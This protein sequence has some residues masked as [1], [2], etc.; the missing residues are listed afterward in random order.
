MLGNDRYSMS[1]ESLPILTVGSAG[2]HN[3]IFS[4][5]GPRPCTPLNENTFR[6]R[7]LETENIKD[8]VRLL[9]E[10]NEKIIKSNKYQTPLFVA[11]HLEAGGEAIRRQKLLPNIDLP[12]TRETQ[13]IELPVEDE[14]LTGGGTVY[15]AGLSATLDLSYITT[16]LESLDTCELHKPK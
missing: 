5:I 13:T 9:S 1:D 16:A 6:V 7:I 3:A 15:V 4:S 12:G 10:T 8:I 11:F 14:P 2:G